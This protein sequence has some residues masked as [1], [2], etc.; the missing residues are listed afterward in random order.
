[1]LPYALFL[2]VS[3]IAFSIAERL[4]PRIALPLW[5]RQ[6]GRDL[7]YL[8]FNAEVVGALVA[9]AIAWAIPPEIVLGWRTTLKL[10]WMSQQPEV[11]QLLALFLVKDLLQWCVHRLLHRVPFLWRIHRV[12]HSSEVLDWLSNWRFHWLEIVVYQT[13]LYLP[14]TLLAFSAPA[15]F[16]CAVL[17]TTLGHFA[18]ANLRWRIGWAAYV[19][20]SPE[21]HIWHHV[22]SSAGP[23]DK[24][25]G[26]S[27]SVWDWLFGTAFLPGHDPVR[28][29]AD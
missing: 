9:I 14:A 7:L 13:A 16:G 21:M 27:L 18:H 5:R 11:V 4:W 1:M 17:S 19:I 20:N 29:G 28:L 8:V 12:H 15:V 26:I 25:F 24:N 3:A 2:A 10:S 22:H 6:F 23:V